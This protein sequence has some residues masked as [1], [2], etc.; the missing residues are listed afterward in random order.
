[1]ASDSIIDDSGNTLFDYSLRVSSK[2]KYAKLQIKPY[3][4][5]EVVIPTRFPKKAVP[6]LIRQHLNWIERQ[7]KKHQ[8][9]YAEPELPDQIQ[10]A[11]DGSLRRIQYIEAQKPQFVSSNNQLTIYA[12]G[13]DQKFDVL[14]NW[15]RHQ[16]WLQLP[17]MLDRQSNHCGLNYQKI[18]IR[19]Q[20]TRWGSCSS[21]GTI[22]LNDQLLFVPASTAEYLMIHELCHTRFMNHSHEFWQLVAS[23]CPDFRRHD[24]SLNQARKH[25]PEWFQYHLYS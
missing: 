24:S 14:R 16:A 13:F 7:L 4:G 18:N 11:L 19:S 23:F 3:L 2:A 5:L 9:E 8:L 10:L 25:I 15:I 22:S 1:M 21:R 20:K 6:E 12:S 17:A